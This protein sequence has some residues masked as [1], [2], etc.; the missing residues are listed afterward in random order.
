MI[1][2]MDEN[3][4]PTIDDGKSV[5]I[6]NYARLPVMMVRGQGS[7]LWDSAGRKYLDLFAGFGAGVLGHSH[8]E[9]VAAVTEQAGRLWHVGNTFYTTPQIEFARHL[10]ETAFP[11]KA[12]FCHSGLE[13]NEAAVKL[14][15]LRGQ[16]GSPKKWK[17]VSLNRSFHGRSMAMIAATGNPAVKAGFEPMVP[18]FTQVDLGDLEGLSS[19][20]D[21]ETAA[22]IVE[23]IQGEGG[24]HPLP[25]D[26]AVELRKMCDHR[27]VTLIFDEVWTGGGRTGKMFGYQHLTDAGGNTVMPDIITLGKAVGGGLPVG[28]MFARPEV[29]DLLVPGKHGC[30]LGGN[31][32]CMAAARTVFDVIVRDKLVDHAAVLGQYGMARLKSDKTVAGKITAVRGRGLMIGIELK[33][34][35]DRLVERGLDQGVAINLTAKNVIRLAPPVNISREDWDLG[36][37]RVIKT[38]AM[39]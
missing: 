24:I 20:V 33:T 36:L 34:A 2:I 17:V 37:D 16:S 31:P 13:A 25:I 15:R 4:L 29:A 35:P 39:L 18:G 14:A 1:A 38:I 19:A 12:F 6:G 3:P 32:I 21:E 7:H 26:Y 27:G 23:P 22:V 28:V 10:N 11:G 30:T 5:L 8:P 9:L